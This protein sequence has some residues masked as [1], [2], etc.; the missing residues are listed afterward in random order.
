M[1]RVSIILLKNCNIA[2]LVNGSEK[3]THRFGKLVIN[4]STGERTCSRPL[5]GL[6]RARETVN[7][8][9]PQLGI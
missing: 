9:S 5:A 2:E 6:D 7:A 1:C 4:R 8:F 3:E